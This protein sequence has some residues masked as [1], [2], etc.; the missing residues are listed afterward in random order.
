MPAAGVKQGVKWNDLNAN[1]I[2]DAGEPGIAGTQIHLFETFDPAFHLQVE[3]DATGNY[4]FTGLAPGNYTVCETVPAGFI[5][6]SPD[7]LT[8]ASPLGEQIVDCSDF[9]GVSGV[10]YRF[11]IS[12]G[13][14]TLS[15]ND[16]GN[17]QIP[18]T[19]EIAG[20]KFD[21]VN[22]NG[23][24]DPGEPGLP[25]WQINVYLPGSTTALA[26][27]TTDVDGT[28]V[29]E[30][31][32]AGTYDVCETM[33]PGWAQTFPRSARTFTGLD[34]A[35][36]TG[37]AGY[38]VTLAAGQLEFGVDFGN[39]LPAA[40]IQV[41][42]EVDNPTPNVGDTVTFTVTV[43][44]NGP[45]PA[46]GVEITDQIPLGLQVTGFTPSAGTFDPASGRWRIGAMPVGFSA[47]LQITARVVAA[48]T[49]TNV[50]V[51]TGG[52]QID[53][54]VPNNTD[55]ATVSP[56][57][58]ADIVVRK[59][60][61]VRGVRA[62]EGVF[63]TIVVRNAGPSPATGVVVVDRLPAGLTFVAATPSVG[64]YDPASGAWTIGDLAVDAVATMRLQA[65]LEVPGPV[66]NIATKTEVNEFDPVTR[67]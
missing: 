38:S 22:G 50:A 42:K 56:S 61:P 24:R 3:T 27:V 55:G 19:G 5:Q 30:N 29:F 35:G 40:D 1:N 2:R 53:P 47:T 7:F 23:V 28:Y 20:V 9:P 39:H 43:T 36:R 34:C 16:F 66:T 46:T 11:L 15:E 41:R 25:G 60:V 21:D 12:E 32:P 44:N 26:T 14:E 54:I 57:P 52:D 58:V 48:G 65:L 64:T 37:G 17:H 49:L 13:T 63:F 4:S 45:D 67:Q 18:P 33:M 31:L 6:T 59:I 8:R 10:G 51:K 62:A